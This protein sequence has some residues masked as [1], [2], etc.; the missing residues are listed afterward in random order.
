ME[1]QQQ[2]CLNP[3][4]HFAWGIWGPEFRAAWVRS[5][6]PPT[7]YMHAPTPPFLWHCIGFVWVHLL[8][9]GC[10]TWKLP[11]QSLD[12]WYGRYPCAA[13][14]AVE[15]LP[16][17]GFMATHLD[18]ARRA[19][20]CAPRRQ[21]SDQA[22]ERPCF[23]KQ[24]GCSL[25]QAVGFVPMACWGGSLGARQV[26]RKECPEVVL[27]ARVTEPQK[28]RAVPRAPDEDSEPP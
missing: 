4:W 13:V 5:G 3:L 9:G 26:C 16:G 19:T 10:L 21:R 6:S 27:A 14:R 17:R 2:L 25:A 28:T 15:V 7:S 20:G 18:G 23:H 24:G 11:P 22:A 1:G 12:L 8:T